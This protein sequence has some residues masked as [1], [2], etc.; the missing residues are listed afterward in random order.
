M[1]DMRR[2]NVAITRAKHKMILIGNVSMLR[3][4]PPVEKLLN[5]LRDDQI[6]SLPPNVDK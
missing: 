4:Y 6:I 3:S 1:S 5:L 2:L